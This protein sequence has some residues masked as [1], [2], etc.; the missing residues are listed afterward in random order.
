MESSQLHAVGFDAQDTNSLIESAF[1]AGVRG[2]TS[3]PGFAMIGAYTDPSG[4]RLAFVQREGQAAV[5]TAGL[6]SATSYRAQVVRFT[7]L[8]ARVALYAPDAGGALLTQ[9]LAMVDDPVAYPQH[10]LAADDQFSVVPA[11]QV[12][13]LAIDAEVFDD[14]D[15]FLASPVS[16]A[17]ALQLA[18]TALMS[19]GL[20]GL[21]ADAIRLDEASPTM[22]MAGT[23]L[24][25]ET[26]RNE[27]TG[28]E[29]QYATVRSAADLSCAFPLD[30]PVAPGN[31]VFGTFYGTASSGTWDQ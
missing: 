11:L 2:V 19:P 8:L 30:K 7:D 23:V 6:R 18:P 3:A 22:L 25:V 20:L 27:L 14:E 12:G 24:D 29:F 31:V 10:D 26:R 1:A 28:I 15:A 13:A 16:R 17:G 21:Q 9:Y 4:A 5:T